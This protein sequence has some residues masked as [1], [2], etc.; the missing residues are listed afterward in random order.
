MF[1]DTS[2]LAN[3]EIQL[4]LQKTVE[5]DPEKAWL[6]AYHFAICDKQGR[7]MGLCE[8]RVGHNPNIYYSGNIGYRVHEEYRGRHY[9]Q[10][11]RNGSPHH[12]L[13]P[14]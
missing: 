7:E 5:G 10:K 9:A 8:L 1:F 11:A 14:R 13:Q 4:C 2:F 3:D 6:P 12:H